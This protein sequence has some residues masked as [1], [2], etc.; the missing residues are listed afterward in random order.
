M[1]CGIYSITNTKNGKRYIGSGKNIEERWKQHRSLLR[2]ARH[3]SRHL[4]AAWDKY[5][6][7]SFA[8]EMVVV[9]EQEELLSLEQFWID[10]FQCAD[11]THGYNIA[12]VAGS[13]LG[14]KRTAEVRAKYSASTRSFMSRPGARDV[15]SAATREAMARPEVRAKISAGVKAAWNRPESRQKLQ[16]INLGR[17]HTEKAKARM[18]A[19][20]TGRKHTEETKEKIRIANIGLGRSPETLERMS[21]AQ[22]GKKQSETTRAKRSALMKEVM[23]RPEIKARISTANRGRKQT[24]EERAKKSIALRG[25]RNA[26]AKL[27][28]HDVLEI[29]RLLATGARQVDIAEIFGVSRGTIGDIKNGR[30]WGYLK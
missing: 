22:R 3:H 18:A 14:I 10:A 2:Q 25:E 19:A 21:L 7:S 24:K 13:A 26:N 12:P 9:C 27:N 1:T 6:E 28:A 23:N 20:Q 8:F 30:R 15:V 11:G 17:K 4:Q 16:T 5:G 29:K